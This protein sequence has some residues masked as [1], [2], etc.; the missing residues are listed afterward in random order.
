VPSLRISPFVSP[1]GPKL[2]AFIVPLLEYAGWA[3]APVGG[4]GGGCCALPT[5]I[6]KVAATSAVR[7]TNVHF[8]IQTS[9]NEIASLCPTGSAAGAMKRGDGA[10]QKANGRCSRT[11]QPICK[12]R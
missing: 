2:K 6:Q 7:G 12:V 5:P 4:G 9:D 11:E 8:I 10:V 3:G 1:S